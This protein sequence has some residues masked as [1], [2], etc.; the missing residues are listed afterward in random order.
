M[1]TFR[2]DRCVDRSF[3]QPLI[4]YSF[5]GEPLI[6]S[7]LLSANG[8]QFLIDVAAGDGIAGSLSRELIDQGWEAL[9]IEPDAQLFAELRQNMQGL[10]L[11]QLANCMG[12][13]G[14]TDLFTGHSVPDEP[15]LLILN[16]P[17]SGADSLATLDVKRFRPGVIVTKD[18]EAGVRRT[19]KYDLLASY[20]YAYS[21]LAGEYSLWV[22]NASEPEKSASPNLCSLLGL[23]DEGRGQAGFD[24]LPGNFEVSGRS[25]PR[26]IMISGWAFAERRGRVPPLV[27]IE[28]FDHTGQGVEYVQAHRYWRPEVGA[29]FKRP[30]LGMSGFRA[31]IPVRPRHPKSLSLRVV[32]ADG[33]RL[34]RSDAELPVQADLQPFEQTARDGLARKFLSG[35]GIEIGALQRPL[36]MPDGCR[37]RYVDRISLD[38]LRSHYP[39]LE[40]FPL[41]SPDFLDDGEQLRRVGTA[42]QDFVIANHF[43]EHSENPI[44]TLTNLLRVIRRGGI[45]YMGVPDK[46]YTFDF[47]RPV[48]RYAVLKQT[49]ETEV[50]PDRERLF[51]EWVRVAERRTGEDAETRLAEL[52]ATNYSIHY[53]VWTLDDLLQVLLQARADFGLPFSLISAVCCDNEAILLLERT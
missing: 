19:R 35:S 3:M 25:D 17:E 1:A 28:L 47:Y 22:R 30:H 52:L 31:L 26:E 51:E 37:V 20:G 21:G 50:R 11:V 38:E 49:Y 6:F 5:A 7:R 12:V 16:N 4:D 14:L 23:T 45:L 13:A 24:P 9:L 10:P 34:Y 39:E 2:A 46:R 48:T 41:Q 27:W 40:Q 53:N 33:S 42:S 29:R 18:P 36:P 43:F 32:Q 44:Q 8:S 15:G